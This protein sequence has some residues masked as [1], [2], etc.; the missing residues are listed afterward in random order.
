ML[1]DD[2]QQLLAAAKFGLSVVDGEPM[3]AAARSGLQRVK[4]TLTQA[5]GS[6]RS[7]TAE[8]SPPV[9]EGAGLQA[10][11]EWLARWMREQHGLCVEVVVVGTIEPLCVDR[12]SFL[13]QVAKEL[14]L[15]VLHHA[16]VCEA[17]VRLSRTDADEVELSVEDHGSGFRLQDGD[18]TVSSHPGFGLLSI[19]ELA[20]LMGGRQVVESSP[21][22]GT[23]VTVTVP[24]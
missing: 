17:T 8:L 3:S 6:S 23:R 2:L 5:I 7:L 15:N 22:R 11:L 21:R 16:G 24:G 14:L 20:E 1:H 4:Q 10:A 19:C 9:L 12:R 18:G 13:F